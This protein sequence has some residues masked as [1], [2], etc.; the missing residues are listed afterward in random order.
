MVIGDFNHDGI[1]DIAE[2]ALPP[3]SAAG[4]DLLTVSLGRADGSF[5]PGASRPV[6]GHMPKSIVTGDFNGDGT[7]DLIVGDDDGSL[8]L[9][10]GDGK[11]SLVAAGEIAHL[12]SVVS[13]TVADFNHDGVPDLA[14]S[15]WR[16]GMVTIFTGQ[17]NG[18][19]HKGWSFRLRMPGIKA[20]LSTADFNG[21][22]VP[23]LA[24]IYESDDGDTYEVML[25]KGNGVFTL[26]PE[27][28][29][30]KDPNAHCVT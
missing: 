12:D 17:G 27:L 2:I 29:Y 14:V 10:L 5:G 3:G 9:F 24:V 26:S 19:F 30:V 8:S 25:G 11:G 13:V 22:G 7:P 20:Q 6:P 16:A 15:D 28:S 21:D 1:P 18:T 4:P 23:D